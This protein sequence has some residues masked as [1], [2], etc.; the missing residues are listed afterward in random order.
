MTVAMNELSKQ[1]VGITDE[2]SRL[3][4]RIAALEKVLQQVYVCPEFHCDVCMRAITH[5]ALDPH[6]SGTA[7]G[8]G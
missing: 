3:V 7:T 2:N 8:R 1:S 6:A 5:A 4:G